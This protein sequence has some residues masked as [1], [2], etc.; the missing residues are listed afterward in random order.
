MFIDGELYVNE[1]N[2]H[3]HVYSRIGYLT[4]FLKKTTKN[5]YELFSYYF[6]F[7]YTLI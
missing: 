6:Q 2:K 1:Y 4:F 7:N 3:P 5:L